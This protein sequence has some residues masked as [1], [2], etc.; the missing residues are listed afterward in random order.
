[1]VSNFVRFI[2]H[3]MIQHFCLHIKFRKRTQNKLKSIKCQ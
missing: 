1:M 2:L 3:G